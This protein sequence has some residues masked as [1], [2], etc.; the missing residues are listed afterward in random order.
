MSLL[1]RF[2]IPLH[3][4]VK[5]LFGIASAKKPLRIRISLL[6]S[7]TIPLHCFG[8]ILPHAFSL[9]I[10]TAKKELRFRNPLIRRLAIPL[11]CLGFI[12]PH[13]FAISMADTNNHLRPGVS[14]LGERKK[15]LACLG[16]TPLFITGY[17]PVKA[18]R[19]G[20]MPRPAKHSRP[21]RKKKSC[22]TDENDYCFFLRP[23]LCLLRRGGSHS[24]AVH[25]RLKTIRQSPLSGTM[26]GRRIHL[27]ANHKILATHV[28]CRA[29]VHVLLLGFILRAAMRAFDIHI[30]LFLPTPP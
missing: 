17:A 18:R 30:P 28:A 9:G 7:L 1:R 27:L 4:L 12:F 29:L 25:W 5:I 2:T 13:T 14:L 21:R 3:C 20:R 8:L 23:W 15:K 6:R 10:A 22:H 16:E 24:S 19:I 11:R 26:R